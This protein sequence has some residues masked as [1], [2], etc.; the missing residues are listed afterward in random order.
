MHRLVGTWIAS[1]EAYMDEGSIND[2]FGIEWKWGVGKKSIVG[3][4]YGIQNKVKTKDY[5]QFIQYWDLV[6]N[7]PIFVQVSSKGSHGS[8]YI[9]R[10]SDNQLKLVQTFTELDGSSYQSGHL[11]EIFDNYENSVSYNIDKNNE[12]IKDRSY[13]WHKR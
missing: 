11:T 13:T 4:L 5:W 3:T 10:I 7:K 9:E 6:E 1:N 8:G 2:S 12:W